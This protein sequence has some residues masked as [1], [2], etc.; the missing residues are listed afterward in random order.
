M[1]I[2]ISWIGC[3]EV[4]NS[5]SLKDSKQRPEGHLSRWAEERFTHW[6]EAGWVSYL[7]PQTMTSGNKL[8]SYHARQSLALK[9]HS[10]Q[11]FS[12]TVIKN[13]CG[14]SFFTDAKGIHYLLVSGLTVI[15]HLSLVGGPS[16]VQNL[17]Y[18]L[19]QNFLFI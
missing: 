15:F 12:L 17:K 8:W 9:R 1:M 6:E 4:G 16:K 13:G 18:L 7:W 19:H 10:W 3:S 11:A 14:C 2:R 5:P